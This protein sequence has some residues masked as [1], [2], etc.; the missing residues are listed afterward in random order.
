MDTYLLLAPGEARRHNWS[1]GVQR[2]GE[3]G[4]RAVTYIRV[5]ALDGNTWPLPWDNEPLAGAPFVDA[6]VLLAVVDQ[7]G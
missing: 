2:F 6:E 3:R 4:S 5:P 7:S 1:L